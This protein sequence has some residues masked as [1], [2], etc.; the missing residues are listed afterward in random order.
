MERTIR[1]LA[2]KPIESISINPLTVRICFEDGESLE[3]KYDLATR[4]FLHTL[5]N[6]TVR[7]IA[8]RDDCIPEKLSNFRFLGWQVGDAAEFQRDDVTFPI[9]FS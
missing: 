3:E 2:A 1:S 8:L 9:V 5:E 7:R 6:V 4:V